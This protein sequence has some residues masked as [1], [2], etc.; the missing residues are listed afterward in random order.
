MRSVELFAGAGG[1]AL[2]LSRAG[3]EHALVIERDRHAAATL[4]RNRRAHGG[5][6]WPVVEGDVTEFP[7]ESLQPEP[8]LLSGGVPCQP[9]SLG[10]KHLGRNDERNL[11]PMFISA[12][13]RLRPQAI[14]IENVKGLL[15]PSFRPYFEYLLRALELPEISSPNSDWQSHDKALRDA[16]QRDATSGLRYRVKARLLNAADFGVP[17]HRE[18][19]FIVGFRTDIAADWDFPSPTHSQSALEFDKQVGDY[20]QRHRLEPPPSERRRPLLL[21]PATL[22][23]MTVRDAIT[24]LPRFGTV[25]ANT[26][27][28]RFQPGARQYPGHVGSVF[29]MPG[30]TLKAG[31]HGVPG[32]ENMLI[33]DDGT[34]R[35]FSVREAARLQTFPDDYAF[36]GTWSEMMRQLGNAVP[37]KLA[38]TIGMF[39]ASTLRAAGAG[40]PSA[41]ETGMPL[42][43]R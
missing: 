26:I 43:G 30:K 24:D 12:V 7:F 1:L 36:C 21:V 22:P 27:Q 41:I 38:Q 40:S 17:Q 20:W 31:V 29:D 37:V 18:R 3:F 33:A 39:I 14:L 13:R 32:G 2:G 28:H 4:R 25:E 19:V 5:P 15:R 34:V 42:H 6:P 23:W 8:D 10:G 35:Y 9:F 16:Q 11:F